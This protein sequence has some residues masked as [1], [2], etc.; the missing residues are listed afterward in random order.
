MREGNY[1]VCVDYVG[2]HIFEKLN[3]ESSHPERKRCGYLQ[4]DVPTLPYVLLSELRLSMGLYLN[5]QEACVAAEQM[6]AEFLSEGV[7]VWLGELAQGSSTNRNRLKRYHMQ[8]LNDKYV[9]VL[10]RKV[11]IVEH[12]LDSIRVWLQVNISL[13]FFKGIAVKDYVYQ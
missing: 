6:K 13:R 8:S 4:V 2:I 12:A 3:P 5:I 1:K 10:A 7:Q 9:W 11:Q